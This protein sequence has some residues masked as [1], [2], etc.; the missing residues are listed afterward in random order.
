MS[1]E[2]R[3]EGTLGAFVRV[4]GLV[5]RPE[6]LLRPGVLDDPQVVVEVKRCGG[7]SES[8]TRLRSIGCSDLHGA[9]QVSGPRDAS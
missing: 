5:D 6:A 8:V 4:A 2:T 9:R 3:S 1:E 7:R